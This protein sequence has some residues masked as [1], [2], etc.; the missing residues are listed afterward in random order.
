MSQAL[1]L[2]GEASAADLPDRV[3]V[4]GQELDSLDVRVRLG[5]FDMWAQQNQAVRLGRPVLG[6]EDED[7]R[8]QA[9]A[10]EAGS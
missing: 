7:E 5:A 1:R 8:V 9:R 4:D 2:P 6:L 3:R 10:L